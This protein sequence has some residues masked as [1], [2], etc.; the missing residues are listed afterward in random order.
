MSL[1][2]KPTPLAKTT[3]IT[4]GTSIRKRPE[5]VQAYLRS[6]AWQDP[7]PQTELDFC[8]VLD[9]E[10]EATIGLL[11]AFVS[12]RGGTLLRPPVGPQDTDDQN[13][14]T[15]QW[16]P[17]GMERVGQNKNWIFRHAV[18]RG[19]D[20]VW[21]VDADLILDR[22]TLFSLISTRAPIACAV[23]W[24]HWHNPT[25]GPTGL[26]AAPQV[27][28][29]HPYGLEGRGMDAA[30]FRRALVDRQRTQVWG[31]GACT[32]I[33]RSVLEKGVSFHYVPGVVREGMMAGED[34]HFCIRAT[35][36][37]IP[38]VAD[39][40]PD[41]F[42][43]YHPG[44]V[45]EIPFWVED[46]GRVHPEQAEL[47]DLVSLILEP[48]EPLLTAPGQAVNLGPSFVRGRLG[49]IP[50]L[51]EL[52]ERV[53]ELPRGETA[54]VGVHF[55]I[56]HPA[57]YLRG[58]RRLVRVTMVD[59][60]PYGFAPVVEKELLQGTRSARVVDRTTVT[61]DQQQAMREEALV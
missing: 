35:A 22:T 51:P 27:W 54:I 28:L 53:Y 25:N 29:Q 45:E 48:I 49:A 46:L 61:A 39:P 23:Y 41:I 1:I 6:L 8:F 43:V 24:T 19:S 15:H 57:S 33:Q 32:L 4:V 56:H 21:L 47:G 38:M 13:P 20:A 7:P 44:D 55:P 59:C 37:H 31:Q 2:L 42:H 18:E 11:E 10:D 9:T 30:E 36:A 58:Q 14:V 52:E 26:C 50:M 12:E 60:K 34:R 40:W 16:S 17:S 3:R 5:V